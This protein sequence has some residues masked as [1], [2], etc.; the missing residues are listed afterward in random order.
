VA[1]VSPYDLGA[2][3]GVQDQV[4]ALV[5][6]LA[7]D[8]HEAWAVAPGSGGPAGTRHVGS[9]VSVPANRSR[10]PISVDPMAMRRVRAAIAGAEVVHV[11]EPLMPAVSLGALIGA[12]APV[13]A[14]FH[15]D[16]SPVV[17][18]T[19]RASRVVLRALVRRANV[20]TAVSPVAAAAVAPFTEARIIPNGVDPAG[21]PQADPVPGRVVFLGRDERRKGL[22]TLLQAWPLVHARLPAAE[23]RVMGADRP[24][25][26]EGVR[27]LGR[28][29]DDVKRAELASASV[30]C[31]P[32]LGGESFGIVLVEAMAAGCAIVASDIPAFRHVGGE[33]VDYVEPGDPAALARAILGLLDDEVR[34]RRLAAAGRQRAGRFTLEAVRAAYLQAYRDAI[35]SR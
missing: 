34:R 5:E 6:G 1:V 9:V 25:G 19:Y 31:A 10:A 13:V 18:R 21:Y 11:H 35:A 20:V 32:N 3:G 4:L 28:V 12:R 17:R 22:A 8:G 33:A 7:G 30:Y 29:G 27:F 26:P 23:L 2:P 15:A 14:T 24:P 16:P